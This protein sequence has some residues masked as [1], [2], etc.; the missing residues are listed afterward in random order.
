MAVADKD[1]REF[2][3]GKL[4]VETTPTTRAILFCEKRF[5]LVAGGDQSGK[6]LGAGNFVA[7]RHFWVDPSKEAEV[8]KAKLYWLVAADYQRTR[9]EFGYISENFGKLGMLKSVTSRVDPGRIELTD[10]TVIET[11]S[12][13]DPR[14]LAMYAPDGVVVC[15]ASQIDM[16][17]FMRLR[18]RVGPSRGW[19]YLSGSFE[20]TNPWYPSVFESWKIGREDAQSFSL[21]TWDN[22]WLFPGGRNDP[23]ILKMQRES[24]D[25]YFMERIA[26]IPMPPRGLVFP[27]FRTELHVKES[28]P[29]IPDLPVYL[30]ID[31]GTIGGYAVEVIQIVSGAVH[32]FDEV[33]ERDKGTSEIIDICRR[34]SWWKN[35]AS[36]GSVV[37]VAGLYRQGA[38]IPVSEIWQKEAGLPTGLHLAGQKIKVV[39]GIERLRTFLKPHPITH[40][41]NLFIDQKCRGIISEFGG[42]LNPFDQQ[43]RTYKWL[44]DKEGNAYG[45]EP[46]NKYNHGI[47]AISYFL[48]DHFGYT[49][50]QTKRRASHSLELAWS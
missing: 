5:I 30:A 17:I 24:S 11:H 9:R 41:P 37:D 34:L 21:P 3:L 8:G 7:V 31:P 33:Y 45:A 22:R 40:L 39:D 23:E 26:G 25:Q 15:E 6:S 18:T 38:S 50:V 35:V 46:D 2:I 32:I 42:C 16:E 48:V 28:I 4:G 44:V 13:Q 1:V 12:A 49:M 43:M 19:M 27:E 14:T 10:G 36:T 20:A 47:K 29:F